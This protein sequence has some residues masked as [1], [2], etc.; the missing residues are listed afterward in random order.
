MTLQLHVTLQLFM[1][2]YS[3]T[4]AYSSSWP[5]SSLLALQL[6]HSPAA[7]PGPTAPHGGPTSPSVL[8]SFS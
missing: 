1:V 3:S 2:A 4:Q 8:Y 7:L 6:S 5:Y